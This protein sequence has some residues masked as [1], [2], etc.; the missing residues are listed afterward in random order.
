MG[1]TED[2][3]AYLREKIE[4]A[5]LPDEADDAVRYA[6]E[7]DI[8]HKAQLIKKKYYDSER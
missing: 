2:L 4:D 3:I 6:N 5:K 8:L 1:K 7:L